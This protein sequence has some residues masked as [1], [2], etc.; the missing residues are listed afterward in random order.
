MIEITKRERSH[1]EAQRLTAIEVRED[2]ITETI[3]RLNEQKAELGK[4]AGAL[5]RERAKLLYGLEPGVIVEQVTTRGFRREEI[6]TEYL[7]TF[8]WAQSEN[9]WGLNVKGRKRTKK[10]WH[11]SVFDIYGGK[12][13]IVGKVTPEE[14]EEANSQ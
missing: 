12:V 13:R 11:K 4:E 5:N 10:G 6:T 8:C 9:A 1:E 7:V 3:Q 14:L 2:A